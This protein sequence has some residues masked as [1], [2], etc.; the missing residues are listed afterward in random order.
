MSTSTTTATITPVTLPLSEE[1]VIQSGSLSRPTS[2]WLIMLVTVYKNLQIS[3]RYVPNLIGRFIRMAIRIAFF[4]VLAKSISFRGTGLSED[5][6][7]TQGL[8][9]FFQGALVLMI[10]KDATL[11]APVQAVSQDLYNGTLEYLYSN[12]GSRY[13][14]YIGT[15]LHDVLLSLVVFLPCYLFLWVSSQATVGSMLMAL[16]VC[17]IVCITLSA[18]GIMFAL[19]VLL[20]RQVNSLLEI[21][22]LLFEFLAGA[23]L[24]VSN[25]PE[26]VQYFAYLLPYTWGY[27]LIRYYSF[28][29]NWQTLLPVWQ[30]WGILIVYAIFYTILSRYLLKKT[31]HRAKRIGLHVI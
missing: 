20:W 21:L 16:L 18:M 4:L 6:M 11:G 5:V 23:Y 29:G 9:L 1:P 19:L 27:D 15:V 22:G 7:T 8:F 17:G 24:P 10:F 25:F 14:Y 26:S 28:D 3:R 30:E 31:E 13:A 2:S 12:P